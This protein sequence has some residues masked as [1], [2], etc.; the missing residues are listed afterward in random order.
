MAEKA[1]EKIAVE[2]KSFLNPSEIS[3]FQE[4]L[5]QFNIYKVALA[6]QDPDRTLYLAAPDWT[7]AEFFED[8]FVEKIREI[9][10]VQLI[11]LDPKTSEIT[12]WKN[13]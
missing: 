6:E 2:I 13:I 10:Q 9:Y 5:G 8:I 1:E 3:D 7:Y 12:A 11:L 4:A